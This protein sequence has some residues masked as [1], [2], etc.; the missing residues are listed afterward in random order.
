LAERL[1]ITTF[2]Q[3]VMVTADGTTVRHFPGVGNIQ[4]KAF[5]SSMQD[6][7]KV[8]ALHDFF[9][10]GF[11]DVAPQSI[12]PRPTFFDRLSKKSIMAFK[13]LRNDFKYLN[14]NKRNATV[15]LFVIGALVGILLSSLLDMLIAP[16]DTAVSPIKGRR[17]LSSPRGGSSGRSPS[18]S[19]R[20][21]APKQTGSTAASPAAAGRARSKTPVGKR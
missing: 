13:Q 6:T 20:S 17:T 21:S 12:A 8:N 11:S 15:V 9:R 16:K 10:S 2:P 14:R 5:V 18:P 7:V 4:E 1:N 19:S 3:A